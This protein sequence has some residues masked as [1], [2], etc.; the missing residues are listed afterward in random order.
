MDATIWIQILND[1][2]IDFNAMSTRLE[3]K[4]SRS[5]YVHIYIFGVFVFKFFFFFLSGREL[6]CLFS[7]I[8]WLIDFNGLSTSLGLFYA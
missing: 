1:S 4:E 2:L 7:L 3:V 6:I 5:L 8:D